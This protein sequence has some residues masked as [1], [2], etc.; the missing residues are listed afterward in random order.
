MAV[1]QP[2]TSFADLLGNAP[3]LRDQM[4]PFGQIPAANAA[5]AAGVVGATMQREGELEIAREEGRQLRR[6]RQG[7][8]G[9]RLRA[10]APVLLQA[11]Q[12]AMDP[13]GGN[14]LAGQLLG[15][16]VGGGQVDPNALLGQVN[17]MVGGLNLLRSQIEPWSAR[18]R[19]AGIGAAGLGGS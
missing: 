5:I 9:E 16:D 10:M 2:G 4:S 15:A 13:F 1:L 17:D 18:T 6:T 7:S 8:M 12:D 14:R 11:S 3:R 19:V